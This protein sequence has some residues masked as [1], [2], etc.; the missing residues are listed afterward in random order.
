MVVVRVVVVLVVVGVV[1]VVVGVVV[2]VVAVVVVVDGVVVVVVSSLLDGELVG[3]GVTVVTV[4]SP[5]PPVTVIVCGATEVDSAGSPGLV[6]RVVVVVG[7]LSPL[8]SVRAR[9]PTAS[10][11]TAAAIPNNSGGRRYQGNGASAKMEPALVSCG[12]NSTI[13]RPLVGGGGDW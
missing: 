2:V 10:A 5:L 8:V 3:G 4:V 13:G 12:S 9:P 11:A 1:V 6:T 7:V